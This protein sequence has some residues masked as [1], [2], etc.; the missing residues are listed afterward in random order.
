[1][2]STR[3]QKYLV[4]SMMNASEAKTTFGGWNA[5]KRGFRT[6]IL[7]DLIKLIQTKRNNVS[8]LAY[9][10]SQCGCTRMTWFATDWGFYFFLSF[11]VYS[12]FHFF[13]LFYFFRVVFGISIRI[14]VDRLEI[15]RSFQWF[16]GLLLIGRQISQL[17]IL[18]SMNSS[19]RYCGKCNSI[20]SVWF[21]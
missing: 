12:L 13:T 20:R 18:L 21:L 15:A 2:A 3:A 1:M 7:N 9:P 17:N 10:F 5:T 6:Y 4:G 11:G 16:Y 19:I 14:V 8:N